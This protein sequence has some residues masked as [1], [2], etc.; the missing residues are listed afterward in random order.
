MVMV[1]HADADH[2]QGILDL[3]AHM[4]SSDPGRPPAP[5]TID[6]LWFNSFED[7]VANPQEAEAAAVMDGLAQ[8]ASFDGMDDLAIPVEMREDD[9]GYC[10]VHGKSVRLQA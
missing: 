4:R 5:V 1:S 10:Q 2:L 3:T 7:L 9:D 8:T 6:K